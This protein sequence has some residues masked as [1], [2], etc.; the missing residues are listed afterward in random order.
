MATPV[1]MKIQSVQI[2]FA[3]NKIRKSI[4]IPGK[5]G[6]R[7]TEEVKE[8]IED[9]T[10][11]LDNGREI[12]EKIRVRIDNLPDEI[13]EKLAK[14]GLIEEKE[15]YTLGK[16]WESFLRNIEKKYVRRT[17]LN[18]DQSEKKF[19]EYF[20]RD[21]LATDLKKEQAQKWKDSLESSKKYSPATIAGF[22][23]NTKAVFNWGVKEGIFTQSPFRYVVKGSFENKKREHFVSMDDYY[24]VLDACPDQDWRTLISLCRIGGLRN[25]SETLLLKWE[26]VNWDTQKILVHSPKTEKKGKGTRVIP[27]FPELRAELE[28][29]WDQAVEGGSPF[30]IVKHRDTE[31]NMRTQFRRIIFRAGF[32]P[33]E[34][35]FHNLRGSRANELFSAYSAQTAA[36][37]MGHTTET[38]LKHYLHTMDDDF[39]RAVRPK[40]DLSSLAGSD[41]AI[42]LHHPCSG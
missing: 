40:E 14:V 27:M 42:N 38:A 16:L 13:Q 10:C 30:V 12:S 4:R 23:K 25:P 31:A 3:I 9:I 41:I 24:K 19:F 18:Y 6:R 26:D 35:C 21:L 37:W 7:I 34:R 17:Y 15:R 11:L 22:M 8:I 33:W 32:E 39:E 29:Q 20:P 5:Y 2:Q 28:K 36:D 1:K